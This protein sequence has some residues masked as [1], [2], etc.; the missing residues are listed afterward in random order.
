MPVANAHEENEREIGTTLTAEGKRAAFEDRSSRRQKDT[1]SSMFGFES[2][3]E[4]H[5]EVRA[6][7]RAMMRIAGMIE[8]KAVTATD[9]ATRNEALALVAELDRTAKASRVRDSGEL[10][11]A[12]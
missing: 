5:Q 6:G 9:P 8:R 10:E 11:Q 1:L 2:M 4:I 12:E 7:S 3:A